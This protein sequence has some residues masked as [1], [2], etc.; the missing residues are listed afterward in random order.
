[1]ENRLEC[2]FAPLKQHDSGLSS[3]LF[4]SCYKYEAKFALLGSGKC[5]FANKG[6][7]CHVGKEQANQL[8]CNFS[9]L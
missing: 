7:I 1:M 4:V 8:V 3:F 2:R 9:S 5:N 6:K